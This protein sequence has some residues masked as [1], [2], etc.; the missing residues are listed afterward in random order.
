VNLSE[1]QAKALLTAVYPKDV[2][3]MYL[4]VALVGEAG[5]VAN[6]VKKYI[7]NDGRQLTPERIEKIADELGDV[8]WYISMMAHELDIPLDAI[9]QRNLDKLAGRSKRG[10][11][12]KDGEVR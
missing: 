2:A 6:Q 11:I 10:T 7:R 5:E 4:G 3:I 8:L 9:A 1:Y 12:A